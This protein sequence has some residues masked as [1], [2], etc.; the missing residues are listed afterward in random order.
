MD[1][2]LIIVGI[3]MVFLPFIC[4]PAPKREWI[5]D[6][7]LLTVFGALFML[8]GLILVIVGFIG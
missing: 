5:G 7:W 6:G 3:A 2:K 1:L 8:C 4:P